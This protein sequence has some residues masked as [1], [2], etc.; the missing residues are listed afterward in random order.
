MTNLR[1]ICKCFV[2]YFNIV[3]ACLIRKR[4]ID[5][6]LADSRERAVID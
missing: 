6:H 3:S 2:L 4:G 1:T 5:L